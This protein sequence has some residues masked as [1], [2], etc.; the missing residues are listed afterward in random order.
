[1]PVFKP[2]VNLAPEYPK[3]VWYAIGVFD[4][5]VRELAD[6]QCV[7]TSLNDGTHG[8]NSKHYQ[9][10]AFDVRT[11]NLYEQ[12]AKD[13][14]TKAKLIL[15]PQGFDTVWEVDHIHCEYDPKAGELFIRKTD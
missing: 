11:K 7:I 2:E 9:S 6:T 12:Q 5:L 13:V 15:D 4:S 3:E 14:C 10:L 8:Q 1:M